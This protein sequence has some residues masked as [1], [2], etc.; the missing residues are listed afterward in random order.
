VVADA[1]QITQDGLCFVPTELATTRHGARSPGQPRW[2]T[3]EELLQVVAQVL[4][5][6]PRKGVLRPYKRPTSEA[7]GKASTPALRESAADA[8]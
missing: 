6:S 3:E 2:L 5:S 1:V 7:S 8:I 4:G